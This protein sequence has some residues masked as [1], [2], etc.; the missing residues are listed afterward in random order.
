ME[1]YKKLAHKL[2]VAGDAVFLGSIVNPYRYLKDCDIYVQPSKGEGFCIAITEA[3]CL[4]KPIVAT[5][6]SG[7]REQLTGRKDSLIIGMH[8]PTL[9]A[10]IRTMMQHLH[11]SPIIKDF[12]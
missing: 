5:D 7:A 11:S 6:F 10:G 12:S 8:A 4:D 2:D 1:E 3:I 9:A